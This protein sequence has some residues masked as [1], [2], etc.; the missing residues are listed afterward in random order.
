MVAGSDGKA[1]SQCKL[2]LHPEKTKVVY[3]KDEKRRG[4]YPNEKFDFLGFTFRPRLAKFR[5]GK[6]GVNFSPAVSEEAAKNHADTP[7]RS[8]R[9]HRRSDKS[10]QIYPTCI[11]RLSGVGST[12]M[13]VTISQPYILFVTN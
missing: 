12:I 11:I 9:F 7:F 1:I 5:E 13:A 2:E 6:Y 4:N 3:C 10:C 8:W